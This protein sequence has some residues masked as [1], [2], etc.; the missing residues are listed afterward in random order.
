MNTGFNIGTSVS[1]DS[2]EPLADAIVRILETGADQK[3]KRH[4]VDALAR[5]ARVEGVTI[6]HCVVNGDRSLHVDMLDGTV[7]HRVP[8]GVS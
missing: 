7:D 1:A 5:M 4:A 3:T 2:L 8:G 6:Q